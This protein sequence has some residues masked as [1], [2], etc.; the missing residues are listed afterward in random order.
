MSLKLK[1]TFIEINGI[2]HT[3]CTV[4]VYSMTVPQTP[5]NETAGTL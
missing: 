2:A 1:I 4:Y 5:S 3:L